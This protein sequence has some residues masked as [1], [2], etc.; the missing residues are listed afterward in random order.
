[1][2]IIYTYGII[3]DIKTQNS[4]FYDLSLSTECTKEEFNN[5]FGKESDIPRIYSLS[6]ISIGN[7]YHQYP[8]LTSMYG[9][10]CMNVYVC[11]HNKYIY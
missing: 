8:L 11:T 4:P 6:V 3:C 9:V 5:C 2:D 10:V 1:M 7:T